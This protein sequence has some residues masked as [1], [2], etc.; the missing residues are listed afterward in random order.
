LNH[1]RLFEFLAEDSLREGS[2][3]IPL[4]PTLNQFHLIPNQK[5]T[6]KHQ[7]M[8]SPILSFPVSLCLER[9]AGCSEIGHFSDG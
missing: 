6:V 1:Q 2:I 9:L 8:F 7:H 3:F 4:A 5:F